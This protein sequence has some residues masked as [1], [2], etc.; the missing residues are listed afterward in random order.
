M[1]KAMRLNEAMK[2]KRLIWRNEYQILGNAHNETRKRELGEGDPT[3]KAEEHFEV[4]RNREIHQCMT[5]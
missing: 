2:R 4:L 1:F 5:E 3:E